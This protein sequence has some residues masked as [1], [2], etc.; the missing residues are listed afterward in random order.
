[1][2][3]TFASPRC[4]HCAGP[5]RIPNCERFE[6]MSIKERQDLV[7]K[8]RLCFNCLYY[9][10]RVDKCRFPQCSKCGKRHH[11][12]L[13]TDGDSVDQPSTEPERVVTLAK[14]LTSQNNIISIVKNLDIYI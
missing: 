5:H 12:K 10:H 4:N 3:K 14:V 2:G 9:G 11:E 13:H 6:A 7:E 1:M 8:N